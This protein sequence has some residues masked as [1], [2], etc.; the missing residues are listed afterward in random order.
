[1]VGIVLQNICLVSEAVYL[2]DLE[3]TECAFLDGQ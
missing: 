3:L 1:M 2:M